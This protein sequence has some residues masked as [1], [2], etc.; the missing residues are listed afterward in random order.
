MVERFAGTPFVH[1]TRGHMMTYGVSRA[2]NGSRPLRLYYHRT[3]QG[4]WFSPKRISYI[5][6]ECARARR[7]KTHPM[8]GFNMFNLRWGYIDPC[9]LQI[10]A[11]TCVCFSLVSS[12]TISSM[13]TQGIT[14][15]W[16]FLDIHFLFS[17]WFSV[18]L[19][20]FKAFLWKR[21]IM[22]LQRLVPLDCI[23]FIG[24]ISP[25]HLTI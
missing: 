12:N 14:N 24:P 10:V 1:S 3:L 9:Y 15:A 16:M 23:W 4:S 13:L 7:V 19:P 17:L 22:T 18:L 2:L 25:T 11:Q 20:W 6:I 21:I 8:T 5:P